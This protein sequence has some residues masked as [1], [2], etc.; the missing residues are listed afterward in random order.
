MRSARVWG[1]RQGLVRAAMARHTKA[2]LT[3]LMYAAAAADRAARGR[4]SADVW[5]HI[6]GLVCA[7]S[8]GASEAQRG[9]A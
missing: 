3:A 9:A 2:S 4:G 8:G 6:T 5:D 7:L 1:A